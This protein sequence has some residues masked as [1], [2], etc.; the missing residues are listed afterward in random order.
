MKSMDYKKEH[1]ERRIRNYQGSAIG[2]QPFRKVKWSRFIRL[3]I[4][5][6]L[7]HFSDFQG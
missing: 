4:N 1:N 2:L 6:S 7:S 5:L 3:R